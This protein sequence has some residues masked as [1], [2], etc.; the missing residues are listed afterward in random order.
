MSLQSNLQ[1][2]AL[3]YEGQGYDVHFETHFPF[4]MEDIP[5]NIA[6]NKSF[7]RL[8]QS[9]KVKYARWMYLLERG[10]LCQ[11]TLTKNTTWVNRNVQ[12]IKLQV[13]NR[14]VGIDVVIYKPWGSARTDNAEEYKN[15][16]LPIAHIYG[17]L[18]NPFLS[19]Q[20][21]GQRA[22]EKLEAF[23]KNQHNV[24]QIFLEPLERGSTTDPFIFWYKCG[25][26]FPEG[27]KL[28][29]LPAIERGVRNRSDEPTMRYQVSKAEIDAMNKERSKIHGDITPQP[30]VK[31]GEATY[32]ARHMWKVTEAKYVNK[33]DAFDLDLTFQPKQ[34]GSLNYYFNEHEPTYMVERT[35][36]SASWPDSELLRIIHY[37]HPD[38][39]SSVD[40]IKDSEQPRDVTRFRQRSRSRSRY[41]VR[42]NRRIGQVVQPS[43]I[44]PEKMVEEVKE[45]ERP[46]R[47]KK[48]QPRIRQHGLI[49]D[50]TKDDPE[51]IDLTNEPEVIDLTGPEVI[52]LT[53]D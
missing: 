45:P 11:E 46:Q 10:P 36:K 53:N 44:Q 12:E 9:E 31:K 28:L 24:K 22:F 48:P 7:K 41:R 2:N 34:K 20:G 23:L 4:D 43:R 37:F 6:S 30:S 13:Y 5:K 8:P 49:I 25:F 42:P 51:V 26:R 39:T 27:E 17:F 16:T 52:D 29:L 40:Q 19:G 3:L 32:T 1:L 33:N 15:L 21:Y 47:K 14:Y 35:A 38:L 50:L 18:V